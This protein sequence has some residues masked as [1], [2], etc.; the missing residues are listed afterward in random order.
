M[1]NKENG[2]VSLAVNNSKLNLVVHIKLLIFIIQVNSI[3][4]SKLEL[5][6]CVPKLIRIR[7]VLEESP[8]GGHFDEEDPS[9]R[10][11]SIHQPLS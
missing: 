6:R 7:Q 10:K 11:V 2:C 3:L 4:H 1:A 8:Y 5:T 9:T